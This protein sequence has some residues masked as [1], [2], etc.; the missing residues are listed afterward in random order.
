M[1]N[2]N[3][4]LIAS[5]LFA[6]IVISGSI[7]FFSFQVKS[8]DSVT[9]ENISEAFLSQKIEEG[10]NNF[11]EKQEQEVQRQA[12]EQ[13]EKG[14][15]KPDDSDHIRGARDAEISIIEYSDFECPFCKKFHPT[16]KQVLEEYPEKVNWVYRHFPLPFHDPLATKEAEASE[17]A[18]ELGGN[19]QFWEYTDLIFERTKSNGK[20]LA[21]SELAVLAEEIGLGKESF[22]ACLDSGKYREHV[23]R[24]TQEGREAGV[25]GT[26]GNFVIHNSSGTVVAFPGAREFFMI[27]EV[28]DSLLQ[29]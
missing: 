28:I 2:K 4:A 18:N 15:K 25:T 20:G 14:L 12:M 23:Q 9:T 24:D 21:L 7:F 27:Q 3:T 5:I 10:I 16:M 29:K 22:Q 8:K 11:I 6:G 17:C 19:E 1:K 13:T 26:P